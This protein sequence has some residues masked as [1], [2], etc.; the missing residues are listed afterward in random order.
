VKANMSSSATIEDSMVTLD[1]MVV[2]ASV[3][4]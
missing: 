2:D 4:T 3:G 1:H